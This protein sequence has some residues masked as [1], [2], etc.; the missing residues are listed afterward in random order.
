MSNTVVAVWQMEQDAKME[1]DAETLR[2]NSFQFVQL[3][4][5]MLKDSY[6]T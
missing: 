2:S 6:R 1:L 5:D 3:S 4:K